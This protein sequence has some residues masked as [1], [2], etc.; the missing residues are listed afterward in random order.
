MK[1]R[2]ILLLLV[3]LLQAVVFSSTADLVDR[4]EVESQFWPSKL[5][6]K[7]ELTGKKHGNTLK[8]GFKG[9]FLRLSDGKCLVDFGHSGIF[10]LDIDETDFVDRRAELVGVRTYASQGLFEFRYTK[11]FFN[12]E[13]YH[14]FQLGDWEWA[15]RFVIVYEEYEPDAQVETYLQGLAEAYESSD[16]ASMGTMLLLVT[17]NDLVEDE[18]AQPYHDSGIN[19]PTV[20]PFHRQGA[21]Y[22][23]QH[24]HAESG[25]LVIIDK[26]GRL[27]SQSFLVEFEGTEDLITHIT[28]ISDKHASE[29]LQFNP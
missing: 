14:G 20:A 17:E 25:D 7:V 23:L 29:L 19:L 26:N 16:L 8:P 9:V 24:D 15:E 6:T 10:K 11:L 13:R 1:A 3:L 18:L 2:A 28:E 22:T 27:L 12:P 21:I 5:S 4:Y